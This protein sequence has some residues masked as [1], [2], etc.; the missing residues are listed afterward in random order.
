MEKQM[1][2]VE[3]N[4][5]HNIFL[6]WVRETL[7]DPDISGNDNFLDAGGNSLLAVELLSRFENEFGKKISMISLLQQRITDAV[8]NAELEKGGA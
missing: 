4:S 6:D 2:S 3:Q 8:E 5:Q 7:D 1:K